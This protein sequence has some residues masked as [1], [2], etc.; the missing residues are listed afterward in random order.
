M[1]QERRPEFAVHETKPQ[2]HAQERLADRLDADPLAGIDPRRIGGFDGQ[3]DVLFVQHLV[4]LEA[5]QQCSWSADGVAG[6]KDRCSWH[7]RRWLLF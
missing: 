6:Q 3:N 4:M 5:M 1:G 2:N 7:A